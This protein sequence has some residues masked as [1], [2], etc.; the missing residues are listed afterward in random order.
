MTHDY[1]GPWWETLKSPEEWEQVALKQWLWRSPETLEETEQR[2]ETAHEMGLSIQFHMLSALTPRQR[3]VVELYC[4]EGRTQIE[5][6][7]TL[8]ISQ[9]TVSQHLMGK[10]RGGHHIG[11][12]FC[13]IRKAIRKMARLRV[14]QN[15]RPAEILNVFNELLDPSITRRRA[16]EILRGLSRSRKRAVDEKI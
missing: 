11:G 1:D 14:R 13:K 8:G 12:A 5:I 4:F 3:Q 10:L 15:S 9:A 2:L 16:N 6:A 7:N